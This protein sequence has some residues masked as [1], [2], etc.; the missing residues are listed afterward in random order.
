MAN[1]KI[2]LVA[3]D[4]PELP[5]WV[6]KHFEEAGYDF[7]FE[8]CTTREEVERV[9]G[10]ADIVWLLSGSRCLHG[11][12]DVLKRC[13]A[14]IRT[15]SGTDNVPVAEATERG[16]VVANTPAAIADTV[17]E[18][19]IGLLFAVTR[20]IAF[21]NELVHRGV[22]DRECNAPKH[23]I[24][25]QTLGLVGFGHIAR[26]VAAKMR[27]FELR[28]LV[29]DPYVDEQVIV[30]AGAEKAELD[31]VLSQADYVSVH[32]PLMDST[33]GLIGVRELALMKP[34]GV[35]INTS[36]GPVVDELALYEAL[37]QQQIA[38]AGLDVLEEEPPPK[39]NPLFGLKNVVLTPHIAPE[40]DIELEMLWKFSAET[41]T[42]LAEGRLP[43]SYV[44]PAV[45]PRWNLAG[46]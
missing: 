32:T 3:M 36:R 30:E 11:N 17:A 28:V 40:S 29:F 10:D 34:T 15:G 19:A 20:K 41:A 14:I 39:D 12:L 6:S 2:A 22:W 25:G 31:E 13:G 45:K 37:K 44:N 16:I 43:R 33:H 23:H 7:V 46:R 42:D 21:H 24:Q 9:A 4:A 38:G 1:F 27:G 26:R 5:G 35:L 8:E 18:H